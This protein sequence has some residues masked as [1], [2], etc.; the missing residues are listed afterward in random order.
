MD[1]VYVCRKCG[2]TVRELELAD[3]PKHDFIN[4]ASISPDDVPDYDMENDC[5]NY[6]RRD[7]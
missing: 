6:E 7:E 1:K 5:E 2:F 4:K 3:W